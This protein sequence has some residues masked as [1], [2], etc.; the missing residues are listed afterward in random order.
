MRA[1]KIRRRTQVLT[2]RF[3]LVC[4]F[5][6]RVTDFGSLFPSSLR[7]SAKRKDKLILA[8]TEH[9]DLLAPVKHRHQQ[10]TANEMAAVNSGAGASGKSSVGADS[11]IFY[12]FLQIYTG[13]QRVATGMPVL[14]AMLQGNL[15][16]RF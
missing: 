10:E 12:D 13:V 16:G 7:C 8:A 15:F 1:Q 2:L 5:D 14:F 3:L 4:G 6:G 9:S 11:N